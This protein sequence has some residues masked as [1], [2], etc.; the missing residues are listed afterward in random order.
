MERHRPVLVDRRHSHGE[1]RRDTAR[2]HA[3]GSCRAELHRERRR[4]AGAGVQRGARPRHPARHGPLHG[5]GRRQPDRGGGGRRSAERERAAGP[6]ARLAR[7]PG[8]GREGALRRPERRR[9]RA[10]GPGRGRQRRGELHERGAQRL[11][12]HRRAR[13]ADGAR[14]DGERADPDR[15]RLARAR[16]AR[17]FGHHRLPHR[18][19]ARRRLELAGPDGGHGRAGGG[20]QRHPR[21]PGRDPPLPGLGDQR[22]GPQ[23]AV[24]AGR[25]DDGVGAAKDRG[26]AAGGRDAEG[27]DRRHR[28]SRRRRPRDVRLPV[29]PDRR[30][31]RDGD[32]RRDRGDLH[33]HPRRRGQAGPGEGELYR[34]RRRR[35]QSR[36]AGERGVPRARDGA[37]EHPGDRPAG[38]RGD[39]PGRRHADGG[40]RRHRRRRRAE[41]RRIQLPVGAPRRAGDPGRGRDRGDLRR[42]RGRPRQAD[43][44]R[45]RIHRRSRFAR[46]AARERPGDDPGDERARVVPGARARGPALDL[47]RHGDGRTGGV[48]HERRGAHYRAWVR[49]GGRRASRGRRAVGPGLRARR[50]RLHREPGLRGDRRGSPVLPRPRARRGRR[51]GARA[52]CVRRDLRLRR[53]GLV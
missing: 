19:L 27:R 36:G 6:R 16:G 17:G 15:P 5:R 1:G 52:A 31:E 3:A 28:G 47:E 40:D 51:G 22:A 20:V 24:G 33:A 53:C 43:P 9:R 48:L 32:L 18:V 2:H 38:D 13:G 50:E 49:R 41:Q 12:P 10:G 45:R 7:L 44:G 30:A 42:G 34:P 4:P 35:G 23:R 21:R 14:G 29:D 8:P 46:R 39:G 25:R 26:A 37:P 11:R